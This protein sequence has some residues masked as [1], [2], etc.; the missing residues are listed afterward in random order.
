VKHLSAVTSAQV[1]LR[2]ENP[3]PQNSQPIPAPAAAVLH[4]RELITRFSHGI[5]RPSRAVGAK[6]VAADQLSAHSPAATAYFFPSDLA[7]A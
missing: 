2:I 1:T 6:P 4:F 7:A 5:T 3:P